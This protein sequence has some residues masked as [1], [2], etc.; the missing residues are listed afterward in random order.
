[1]NYNITLPSNWFGY[2]FENSQL[3][4]GG[5]TLKHIK[6]LEVVTDLFYTW[7]IMNLNI[8]QEN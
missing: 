6:L 2:F 5:T 1:M 3:R 8:R 7:K 4:L